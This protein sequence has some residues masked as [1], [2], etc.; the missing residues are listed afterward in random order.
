MRRLA[1]LSLALL[2]LVLF[3]GSASASPANQA[4]AENVGRSVVVIGVGGL[5]WDHIGPQTPGLQAL[6]QRAAVGVL[7][8]KTGPPVTC[9]SEG[10]LTLGA[11][12]RA[13]ADV[14]PPRPC[15]AG[16]PI[17]PDVDERNAD[18]RDGAELGLLGTVLGERL[19]AFG[20]G[21]ALSRDPSAERATQNPD[22][23]GLML[24]DAGTLREP[25]VD[26][27]GTP[28]RQ[29]I[30]V[31]E[32]VGGFVEKL[33][34]EADVLLVGLSEPTDT[35]GSSRAHL[36]VA[37]A[38]GPS[39]PRGALRSASTR[40][41]PYVQLIDVA[42]TAL[43]LLGEQVPGAMD[44][45]P[46]TVEGPAPSIDALVDLDRQA[47]ANKQATVPFFVALIAAL[48]VLLPLLRRRARA[49]RAVA[50]AGAAAPGASYLANLVPWWRAPVPVLALLG[51]TLLIAAGLATLAL[52]TRS[53]AAPIFAFSRPVERARPQ[54]EEDRRGLG[55]DPERGRSALWP[56]GVVALATA[57]IIGLDLATGASLQIDS[58]IGYSSLVAGRFAGLGNVAFGVYAACVLLAAAWLAS[59]V[60][61]HRARLTAVA[62]VGLVAVVLDGAPGFGSDV[63]GV[64][65]LVPA[66]VLL[67][68]LVTGTRVS[69]TRLA[70]ALLAAAVLVGA[71][72]L[73]DLQRPASERT[74]LGRFAE[75]LRDGTAGDL[76]ARKAAAVFGLLFYSPVT[77]LL[78][79][80]VAGAVY[81]VLRPPAALRRTFVA[82]PALRHALAAIGLACLIGFGLND[83]GAAVPALALLVTIP[84]VLAV[85]AGV[86]RAE[87]ERAPV[88]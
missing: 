64:L 38:T 12:A 76:L 84:A 45:L 22:A 37:M 26:A 86:P 34:P 82:V 44:G 75:Q 61:T 43:T 55:R 9:A 59:T 60:R 35:S 49:L 68:M 78:P 85:V 4:Q 25:V 5:R 72:A 87:A 46:W 32:T 13:L 39:F 41:A 47:V 3:S 15:R 54:E 6:A 79:L 27:A 52:L 10:W 81:L 53:P 71:F 18:G 30:E 70:A 65:A 73:L 69:L 57:L 58:V 62:S 67:A 83:S 50:L 7:S 28:S 74:H 48:L 77:A 63:G 19:T 11:G 40:R 2:F 24:V 31:D 23:P 80:V 16:Y 66:F 1:V 56:V 20:A 88:A 29:L 36:H 17:G 8:V 21:A 51:I 14:D 42:P 33:G